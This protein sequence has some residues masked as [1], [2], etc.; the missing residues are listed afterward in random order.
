MEQDIY[1][2]LRI[3]LDELPTGFPATL[4]GIEL[5]ILKKLFT[6]EEAELTMNLGKELE[7]LPRIAARTGR[8]EDDLASLLEKMA[9][10][11]IIYR[12]RQGNQVQYK[13]YQ[14][15]IGIYEFQLKSMDNEFSLMFEEYLPYFRLAHKQFRVIPVDSSIGAL[16]SVA[17]YNKIKELVKNQDLIS[18]TECICRK[19]QKLVGKG[20]DSPK[21]TC[22]AFGT[23]A[24]FYIDNK[25]GRIITAEEALKVLD[26]AE[27]AGLVLSPTNAQQL[28]FVCCCCTCCCAYLRAAKHSSK[29][30]RMITSY[31][32]SKINPGLCSFC[33]LCIERCPMDAIAENDECCEIIEEKCIGCGLCVGVCPEGAITLVA[34]SGVEPPPLDFD[35]TLSKIE[36]ERR[37]KK[38]LS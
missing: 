15:L 12:A 24:Q 11:G 38:S 5:K 35:E 26:M 33:G 32:Q 9:Q 7:D 28:E 31:Y 8:K 16:N 17:P 6:P 34:K 23:L 37:S 19:E 1:K 30:S 14:F 29:A 13:A 10:K 18:L 22:L 4:T 25:I 36:T 21:E 3:F 27:E 20:C 2:R